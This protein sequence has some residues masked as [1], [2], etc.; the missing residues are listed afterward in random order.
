MGSMT[1]RG[2]ILV[3]AAFVVSALL[4]A[5]A[6]IAL[7]KANDDGSQPTRAVPTVR[8]TFAVPTETPTPTPAPTTPAPTASP[9]PSAAT[10][11]PTPTATRAPSSSPAPRRTSSPRPSPNVSLIPGMSAEAAIDKA[12]G[13]TAGED[14][15]VSAHVTDGEG[16][17]YLES[18]DWGDGS[19]P[20]Q[21]GRGEACDP[22]ATRPADCRDFSWTHTYTAADSYTI[23]LTFVSGDETQ[24][25][26]LPVQVS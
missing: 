1:T 8:P 12:T 6:A 26:H 18:L 25:L 21:G 2:R 10:A 5:G 23:T 16:T 14:F 11:T 3:V 4:F 24:I 13:G 19:E 15:T 9:T 17:I 20:V 22:A 7:V